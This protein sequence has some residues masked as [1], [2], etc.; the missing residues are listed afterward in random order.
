MTLIS[1]DGGA[2]MAD[3]Y[4]PR[5]TGEHED[6]RGNILKEYVL[7]LP[8]GH[9]PSPVQTRSCRTNFCRRSSAA[10][11]SRLCKTMGSALLIS[12]PAMLIGEYL[13]DSQI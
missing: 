13:P 2:E 5:S 4:L 3:F 6:G 8:D 9:K 11:V 12:T 1:A 7:M 10:I